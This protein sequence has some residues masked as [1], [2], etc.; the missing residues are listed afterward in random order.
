M[1]TEYSYFKKH[2]QKY[3]VGKEK[4]LANGIGKTDQQKNELRPLPDAMHK[5]HIKMY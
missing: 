5:S 2:A 4:S 1:N 3:E